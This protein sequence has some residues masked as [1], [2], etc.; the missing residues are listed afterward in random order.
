MKMVKSLLLVSAAGL[1][2][3]VG[4]TGRRSSRKGQAGRIREGLLPVRRGVL[5]H[6]R[7]RHLHEGRRLRPLPG[8]LR[9]PGNSIS[10][11]PFDGTGGRND[12]RSTGDDYH[13]AH[14]RRCNFDTRQQTAYGT[15]RTYLL[16]GFSQ[17]ID[18]W[19]ADDGSGRV[20]APAPSSRS[21]ASRSARRRRSSTSSRARRWPTTLARRSRRHR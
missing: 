13:A 12:P 17:D 10:G 16:M 6:P 11:G 15:L 19:R 2:A 8:R 7:H 14:P 9:Q 1:V 4:S 18:G 3:V 20:H 21:R 5:L